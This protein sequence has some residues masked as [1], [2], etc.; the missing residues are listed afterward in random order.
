MARCAGDEAERLR[1]ALP[2]DMVVADADFFRQAAENREK[3][4]PWLGGD[5]ERARKRC[6]LA[7]LDLHRAFLAG[8][9]D[10]VTANLRQTM[11]LLR[12]KLSPSGC[13]CR[14]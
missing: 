4:S 2:G 13:G 10:K 1:A 6:F 5:L 3:A 7:A 12:G 11:D 8:A 14:S 9:H